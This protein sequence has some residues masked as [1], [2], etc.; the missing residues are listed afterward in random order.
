MWY[1]GLTKEERE[2]ASVFHPEDW[3]G[4][5]VK[6]IDIYKGN[7][8]DP[9]SEIIQYAKLDEYLSNFFNSPWHKYKGFVIYKSKYLFDIRLETLLHTEWNSGHQFEI[10]PISREEFIKG[11]KSLLP[12]NLKEIINFDKL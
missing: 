10:I 9:F 11:C 12:E 8:N 5:Y 2:I 6:I 3:I 1:E 4:E 7:K